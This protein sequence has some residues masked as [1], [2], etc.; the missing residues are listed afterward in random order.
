VNAPLLKVENLQAHLHLRRGVVKAVEGM[1]M[2]L[3][4]EAMYRPASARR[5]PKDGSSA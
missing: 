5:K 4:A 1:A 3:K 2:H